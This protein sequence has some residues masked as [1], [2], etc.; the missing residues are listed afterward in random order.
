[1][2]LIR[3]EPSRRS[4]A[5]VLCL[6]ASSTRRTRPANSGSAFSTSSHRAMTR[7]LPPFTDS[8]VARICALPMPGDRGKTTT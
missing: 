2:P 1:M 5:I 3:G 7:I 4:V 6:C 8:S